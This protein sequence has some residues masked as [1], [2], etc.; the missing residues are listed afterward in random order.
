MADVQDFLAASRDTD[1]QLA[2]LH[3]FGNVLESGIASDAPGTDVA[4]AVLLAGRAIATAIREVGARMD[5]VCRD[6]R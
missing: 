4:L 3:S 6:G 5:Y 1:D 2:M